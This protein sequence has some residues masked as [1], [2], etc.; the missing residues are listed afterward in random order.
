MHSRLQHSIA[1]V[2]FQALLALLPASV[3]AATATVPIRLQ[4]TEPPVVIVRVQGRDLP[5]QLDLGDASSLVLHPK[6]LASLRREPTG[7]RFKAFS[8]DGKID[9]PIFRIDL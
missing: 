4:D 2:A 1:F 6:V 8:M 9:T 3:N 7:N 5:L